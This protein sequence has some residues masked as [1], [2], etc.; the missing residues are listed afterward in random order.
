MNSETTIDSVDLDEHLR[1][2]LT[3]CVQDFGFESPLSVVAVGANGSLCAIRTDGERPTVTANYSEDGVFAVPINI[4][5][6]DSRGI[7]AR[8]LITTDGRSQLN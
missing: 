2:V 6:T 8:C 7:A 3:S 5:V 1:A 4:M